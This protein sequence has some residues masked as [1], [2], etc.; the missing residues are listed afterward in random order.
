MKDTGRKKFNLFILIFSI[1]LML[2]IGLGLSSTISYADAEMSISEDNKKSYCSATL[3]DEF[4]DDTIIEAS[5]SGYS[6]T[7]DD[8][9]DIDCCRVKDLTAGIQESV[10]YNK[11]TFNK[12][13][14]LTLSSHGKENVLRSIKILEKGMILKAQSRIT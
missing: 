3:E 13:L 4:A 5:N 6:Y 10:S 7:V 9:K 2:S 14:Q 8:F 12:I 11:D 1:F